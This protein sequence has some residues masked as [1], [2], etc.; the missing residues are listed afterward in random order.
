MTSTI[1]QL[2]EQ[3]GFS[4]T[5]EHDRLEQLCKLTAEYCIKEYQKAARLVLIEQEL[6]KSFGLDET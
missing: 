5:Y 4:K 3:A 6:K 2:V 1:R